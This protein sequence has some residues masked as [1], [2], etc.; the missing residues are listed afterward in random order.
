MMKKASKV[1]AGILTASL[2]VFP[3]VQT[4]HTA[5]AAKAKQEQL[6]KDKQQK[7]QKGQPVWDRS[8]LFFT[9]ADETPDGISASIKNGE[10]SEAMQG[11]VK[12]EVYWSES[13]NPKDGVIV[14][15]GVVQP[16]AP[17]ET[18]V[19]TYNPDKIVDGNY[20]FKAYQR[21]DHPG[22][23]VLWSESITV[24]GKGTEETSPV[25]EEPEYPENPESPE[26]NNPYE[27]TPYEPNP[28]DNVNVYGSGNYTYP[29]M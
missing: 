2:L 6:H 18:Q 8:S 13:G 10:D 11:E 16:L 4:G 5:L 27:P 3:F 9:T 12:Y 29:G 15:S 22:T 23:G 19:L 1:T 21:E 17:G 25:P 14:Y 7:E 24:S 26:N 20:M 28:Y